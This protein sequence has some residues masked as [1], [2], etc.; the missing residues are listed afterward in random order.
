MSHLGRSPVVLV[1]A[2]SAALLLAACGGAASESPGD[3]SAEP[4][5]SAAPGA[6]SE[7][8]AT[9][10]A[11][12]GGGGG[13]SVPDGF[14]D[15]LVPPNSSVTFTQS[16]GATQTIIFHSTSSIDELKSFYES[17]IDGLGGETFKNEIEGS[18]TIGWGDQATGTGGLVFIV[19]S[20]DGGGNDVSVTTAIGA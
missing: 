2:V 9:V 12:G 20:S 16:T 5:A 15:K 19:P 6:S 3:G 14:E 18:F 4:G 13:G 8:A 17:A 1:L 10:D 11:G 7:P